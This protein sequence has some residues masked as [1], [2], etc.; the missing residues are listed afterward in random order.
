MLGLKRINTNPAEQHAVNFMAASNAVAEMQMK[1]GENAKPEFISAAN[2]REIFGKLIKSAIALAN[3]AHEKHNAAY[4]AFKSEF[5]SGHGR[6]AIELLA[7]I[8]RKYQTDSMAIATNAAKAGLPH[9]KAVEFAFNSLAGN[10]IFDHFGNLQILAGQLYEEQVIMEAFQNSGDMFSLPQEAGGTGTDKSRFRMPVEQVT[11]SAKIA[12]GDINPGGFRQDDNNRLQVSLFNEFKNAITLD[13]VFRITQE[14]RDQTLGYATAVSP[15]LAGFILQNRYFMNAQ[16]QVMKIAEL[17]AAFGQDAASNYTPNVGGSYGLL[18]TAI[19][20]ALSDWNTATPT[21]A[22][23]SDWAG[24]PTKLIQKIQNYNWKPA[25]VTAPLDLTVDTSLMYKDIVRLFSLPA[26]QNIEFGP[27][28]W[29]LYVPTSWYALGT[30]Y[31]GTQAGGTGQGTFNKQL[32]EMVK[33]AT[34]ERVKNINILPSSL[35]NYGV[36]DG[37][38][39]S[40]AYNYMALVAQGCMSE[41]KP[42]IMPGQTAIPYISSTSVTAMDMIFRAQYAFGGPMVAHFGG[43]FIMEISAHS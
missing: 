25:S 23:A 15:A 38:G 10:P 19:Q 36:K 24:A 18:S 30:Q 29:N 11:G 31:P 14:Q 6:E 37:I 27:K 32:E 39:G 40:N 7:E 41:N 1:S 34:G 17:M 33:T 13:Q 3:P 26:Q 22:Q 20:L 9:E 42:V 35:F 43:A 5:A 16:K 2:A 21:P 12:Q 28:V 8:G 4:N